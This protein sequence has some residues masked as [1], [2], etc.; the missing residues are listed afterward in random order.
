VISLWHVPESRN[1]DSG[2]VDWLGASIATFGLAALIYGF[3]SSSTLGWTHFRVIASLIFG[4]G[5]LI[6]FIFVE[7]NVKAPMVPLKLF[8]VSTFSGANLLTLFLYAA[9]GVFFFM[10]PLNLIQVQKYS[11][12][13]TGAAALPMILLMFL[14]SRWSGGLVSRYGS[15]LP[16]IVGP[17]IAAVGFLLFVV[18]GVH[19]QYWIAFFP[20]FVVLGLGMAVTVAPLTTVV[21]NSTGQERV[22]AASGI[23][24][25]V[26]R[27][28]G[29][30]AVAVL[31]ALMT[32]AFAHS[33]H[34][35]LATLNLKADL[36]HHLESNL[37]MLGNLD[38]PS[39]TDNATALAIRS[40]IAEAFVFGFRLISVLCAGLAMASA[41][42]AWWKMPSQKS[43]QAQ[44]FGTAQAAD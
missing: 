29:V 39:G 1:P 33:L 26:A 20:A 10:F 4:V 13:A 42:V 12:T 24:N 8:Q 18:P 5:S 15:K 36:A 23:N 14:L 25:A 41:L 28:A 27:V 6:L 19:A 32:A 35:S 17:L 40:R 34:H 9:L 22:G 2:T 3:L 21:M 37:E 44:D 31:G 43:S 38:A 16:L 7:K 11:A 30:L